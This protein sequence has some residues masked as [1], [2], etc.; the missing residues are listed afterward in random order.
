MVNGSPS[1]SYQWLCLMTMCREMTWFSSDCKYQCA[2]SSP[3]TPEHI[4]FVQQPAQPLN[5]TSIISPRMIKGFLLQRS[6]S[7]KSRYERKGLR[8]NGMKRNLVYW[9]HCSKYKASI[10]NY[11]YYHIGILRWKRVSSTWKTADTSHLACAG[12]PSSFRSQASGSF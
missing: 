11:S 8:A 10:L 6:I 3:T 9:S 5:Q 4:R 1:L 2:T 7:T 12:A